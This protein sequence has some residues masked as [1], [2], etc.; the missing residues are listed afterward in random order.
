MITTIFRAAALFAFA[1]ALTACGETATS[2]RTVRKTDSPAYQG[3]AN[4]FVA[5]GWKPGDASSWEQ[6][7]RTR[8]QGQNEYSRTT[9]G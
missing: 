9:G 7:M 6:Q 4:P 1:V 5:D 3:A 8:A 2:D